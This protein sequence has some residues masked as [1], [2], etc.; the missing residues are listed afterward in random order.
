MLW[1]QMAGNCTPCMQG[2]LYPKHE[3]I[4]KQASGADISL[5]LPTDG[6]G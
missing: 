6:F 4:L 2:F 3:I 1:A 5:K